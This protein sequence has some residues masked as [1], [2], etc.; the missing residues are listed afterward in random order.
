[1]RPSQMRA[2]AAEAT[3]LISAAFSGS[4][5]YAELKMPTII[6]AGQNDRLIDIKQSVRLH[7]E[8]KQSK[9]HRID[10][11]GHMIHHSATADVMAAI[12]EAAAEAVL[13]HGREGPGVS[14]S[15]A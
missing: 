10:G 13:T 15:N 1:L 8:V 3:M 14:R 4:K 7:G 9:L 11:A 5:T 6:I 12:D 2:T